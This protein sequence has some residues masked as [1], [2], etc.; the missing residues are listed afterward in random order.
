MGKRA[1]AYLIFSGQ[2][3]YQHWEVCTVDIPLITESEE[4]GILSL[5]L[6]LLGKELE[7]ADSPEGNSVGMIILLLQHSPLV[8]VFRARR[9]MDMDLGG[10]T[11]RAEPSTSCIGCD[12]GCITLDWTWSLIVT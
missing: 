6:E 10:H 4:F 2:Q 12:E 11:A 9:Y 7:K 1:A 8:G 5:G 3:H